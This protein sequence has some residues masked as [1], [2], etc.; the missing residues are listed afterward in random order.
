MTAQ[1]CLG[2]AWKIRPVFH[3][4]LA[5]TRNQ[6]SLFSSGGVASCKNIRG[7][8]NRNMFSSLSQCGLPGANAPINNRYRQIKEF[9]PVL[10]SIEGNIG[11]GKTTLLKRLR[12]R[13]PEWIFIDEPVD[14]WSNL[15]NGNGES[16]LEIFYK[17]RRRWSY[18]FQNCAL[19]TRFQNIENAVN[20]VRLM[21]NQSVISDNNLLNYS[22][23]GSGKVIFLTERCLDTDYHVFT[24]M[25]QEDGSIDDLE[26]ELYERLL[27]Q[28]KTTSTKLSAIV[29]VNT[30]PTVCADRIRQRGRSGE[31]G[32]SL[33]YLQ[34]LDRYQTSWVN[35]ATIPTFVTD[36]SNFTAVEQFIEELGK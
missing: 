2:Y 15:K 28:L 25:L 18:T 20:R 34:M 8:N 5:R 4:P 32:I 35:S 19:L 17:D 30:I 33:D 11:A 3:L 16:I 27:K 29:H 10:I 13:H 9:Q 1:F 14:T 6:V 24:R 31:N 23:L 21:Y 7:G 12:E 26:I 22:A 36:V